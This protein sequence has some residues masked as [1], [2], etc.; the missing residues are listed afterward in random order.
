MTGDGRR[1]AA[2]LSR[3]RSERDRTSGCRRGSAR[4]RRRT[5]PARRNRGAPALD[6]CHRRHRPELAKQ[7]ARGTSGGNA[8]GGEPRSRLIVARVGSVAGRV[9][10]ASARSG[11]DGRVPR[12]VGSRLTMMMV[13][14]GVDVTM[15]AGL[16]A[17]GMVVAESPSA[18]DAQDRSDQHQEGG[19]DGSGHPALVAG[20]NHRPYSIP[21]P[22]AGTELAA[23]P[24]RFETVVSSTLGQGESPW[25]SDRPRPF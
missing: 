5:Q 8:F 4:T 20:G 10:V 9:W 25:S 15:M 7:G 17:I 3:R 18:G 22:C 1:L 12:V 6:P 14:A 19:Q 13:R 16:A 23:S 21:E 24:D 11:L 2:A